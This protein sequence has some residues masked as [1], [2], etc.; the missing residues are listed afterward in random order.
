[1][2]DSGFVLRG[3]VDLIERRR[4]GRALRVT[5]HKTGKNRAKP[6]LM[7]GGGTVLQPVLYSLAVERA[8][9]QVSTWNLDVGASREAGRRIDLIFPIRV[10]ARNERT[11]GSAR[12]TE[13][14][15]HQEID[16]VVRWPRV[17]KWIE[18]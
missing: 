1:M 13:I 2:I 6:G 5:D 17:G 14:R 7:I 10:L 18:A 15:P 11:S 16:F 9:D 3:S 8:L 12:G 4:D